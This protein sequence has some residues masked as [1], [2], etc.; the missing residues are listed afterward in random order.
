MEEG[1]PQ[2]SKRQLM[3]HCEKQGAELD[4]PPLA[5]SSRALLMFLSASPVCQWVIQLKQGQTL[6]QHPK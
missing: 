1:L 3:G 2:A 5:E 4:G 6:V